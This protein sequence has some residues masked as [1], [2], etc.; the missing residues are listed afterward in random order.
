MYYVVNAIKSFCRGI[1][2]EIFAIDVTVDWIPRSFPG[3]EVS[4]SPEAEVAVSSALVDEILS[5]N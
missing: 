2:I 3:T 1:S 5:S 4:P